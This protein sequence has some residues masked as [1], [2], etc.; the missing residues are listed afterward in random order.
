MRTVK[1]TTRDIKRLGAP[2]KGQVEYSVVGYPAL[3][4]RVSYSGTKTFVLHYR[5]HYKPK[6]LK[7]GVFGV[8]SLAETLELWRD[9]RKKVARGVDP[10]E[11][12]QSKLFKDVAEEWLRRDQKKNRTAV[13]VR[14]SLDRDVLPR[15][16]DLGM[17]EITD[18]HVTELLDSITDR[19]APVMANRMQRRLHRLF[20]WAKSRKIVKANPL[21]DMERHNRETSR[22]KVLTEDELRRIWRAA[23]GTQS[24]YGRIVQLL[25]LTCGRRGMI[26]E[27][28]RSEVVGDTITLSASRMK[29]DKAFTIPLSPPALSVLA[30]AK[31][32]KGSDLVFTV[33]GKAFAAWHGSKQ[34]LDKKSGV[35]GWTLHDLRTSIATGLAE[36]GVVEPVIDELLSHAPPKIR[37]IYQR[38]S[39][40]P[41]RREALNEWGAYVES[42]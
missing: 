35:T 18:G 33:G 16:G 40:L 3:T 1:S 5:Y 4:V 9:A 10:G 26:A 37:K 21:A 25:I 14:R 31:K 41:E 22:D 28:T 36:R 29:N 23:K 17:A 39:Y 15:W 42:L 11:V 24:V 8:V 27:L 7:L 2:D 13:E 19:G 38:H 30:E 32:I 20:R 34:A 12:V 6:R